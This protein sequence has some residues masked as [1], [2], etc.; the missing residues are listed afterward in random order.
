MSDKPVAVDTL[1]RLFARAEAAEAERDEWKATAENRLRELDCLRA[2][3]V[4][5]LPCDEDGYEAPKDGWVCFHCGIRFKT[6]RAANAHFGTSP[7]GPVACVD[8]VAQCKRLE[9]ALQ[10]A[11]KRITTASSRNEI[12]ET[13]RMIDAALSDTAPDTWNPDHPD[14]AKTDTAQQKTKPDWIAFAEKTG[15]RRGS[16]LMRERAA[17]AL[18]ASITLEEIPRQ[19]AANIVRALPIDPETGGGDG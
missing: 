1:E 19:V 3:F 9:K 15:E 13:L 14:F 16:G 5:T 4:E 17:R 7:T 2:P 10:T 12:E 8:A 6:I 18:E 11:R